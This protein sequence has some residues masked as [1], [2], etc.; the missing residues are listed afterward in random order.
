MV[1]T[2]YI[3]TEDGW[4]SRIG[5]CAPQLMRGTLDPCTQVYLPNGAS[6]GSAVF[7]RFTGVTDT[8]TRQ[9]DT[10]TASRQEKNSPLGT[11]CID[12]DAS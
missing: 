1:V 5:Q 7:A 10:Q 2:V 6:I 4:F 9:T 12:G 3:A 8:Q 11:A